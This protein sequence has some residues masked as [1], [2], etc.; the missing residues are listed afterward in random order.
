[1]TAPCWGVCIRTADNNPPPPRGG[2]LGWLLIALGLIRRVSLGWLI[3]T[4]PPVRSALIRTANNNPCPGRWGVMR[5]ANNDHLLLGGGSLGQLTMTPPAPASGRGI[6][7]GKGTHVEN[8][9]IFAWNLRRS[10]AGIQWNMSSNI[11]RSAPE[12][13][14][15]NRRQYTN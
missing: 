1:M 13:C 3:L 4:Y 12:F 11:V 8:N 10:S 6:R 2:S 15:I 9:P 14:N 7:P 5:M